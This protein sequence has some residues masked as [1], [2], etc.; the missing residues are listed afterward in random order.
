M[1]LT[2]RQRRLCGSIAATAGLFLLAST[3]NSSPSS[4]DYDY[5]DGGLLRDGRHEFQ[6][7]RGL[8]LTPVKE[9]L[10]YRG[11]MKNVKAKPRHWWN[12]IDYGQRGLCGG[13]KCFFLST[14]NPNNGY[15]ISN[16]IDSKGRGFDETLKAY[17]YALELELKYNIRHFFSAPPFE[18]IT[19][20]HFKHKLQGEYISFYE[21]AESL[22]IQPSH[23]A[24]EGSIIIRCYNDRVLYDR[25]GF[26]M[27][28]MN[29]EAKQR[30][31]GG[32]EDT[33]SLV[34]LEPRLVKDFQLMIG[35][36]GQTYHLD[37]DRVEGGN[38]RRNERQFFAGCLENA[39]ESVKKSMNE[40]E[41][42]NENES[43]VN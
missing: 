31:I 14:S 11:F 17:N 34:E 1:Q 9:V 12:D 8:S 35:K 27:R 41:S 37:L 3:I 24:P 40:N 22:I 32:L 29:Q 21:G 33:I 30:L 16:A 13:A 4:E 10:R 28:F 19:P 7:Y 15:L 6:D 25:L 43:S 42:T 2:Q 5:I 39:I 26:I 23:T 20:W 36:D 18:T 38:P